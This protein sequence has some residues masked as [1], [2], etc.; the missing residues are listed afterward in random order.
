M[1]RRRPNEAARSSLREVATSRQEYLNDR[2]DLELRNSGGA[3]MGHA[4]RHYGASIDTLIAHAMPYVELLGW[5][6]FVHGKEIDTA[7]YKDSRRCDY[8]VVIPAI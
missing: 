5:R 4:S 3:I 1:V 2:R 8:P 6:I 7:E